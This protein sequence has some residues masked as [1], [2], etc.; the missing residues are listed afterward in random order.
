MTISGFTSSMAMSFSTKALYRAGNSDLPS[1][2]A[3]PSSFSA[4]D[5]VAQSASV[6]P[7]VGSMTTVMIFSGVSWA[8]ASMSMPPSVETTK[9]MRP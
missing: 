4:S 6:T 1:S 7:V 8:T 9:E 2:R 3:S 5:R